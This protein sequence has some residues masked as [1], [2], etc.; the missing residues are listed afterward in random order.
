MQLHGSICALVTPFDADGGI[1]IANLQRLIDWHVDSGT[2]ALVLAGST[3]EAALLTDDEY[4]LLLETAVARSAGRIPVI[5]GVGSPATA[6]S[7][8]LARRAAAIGANALLAVTPYYVRPTQA[9]LLAHYRLLAD[10]GG[11]PVLLYNVPGRTGCDLLPA[12]VAE[13]SAHPA[14]IGIKEA[15]TDPA[16]RREL[17]TLA[18]ADFAVFCGD[19][20][21][22]LQA[23][24]DGAVGTISVAA[25]VVPKTFARLC[26]L[27]VASPGPNAETLDQGLQPLYRALSV[28]SN[29]IPAKWLLHRLGRIDNVL[30]LPLQALN[31]RY[32]AGL[33]QCL[34]EV[35]LLES[36]LD[37]IV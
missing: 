19:D 5:A 1:D 2:N 15:V 12:T 17:L 8:R 13:L 7:L 18:S 22:A 35:Q 34:A 4:A 37:A 24:R 29:P 27:A 20:G 36:R 33:A 14:I 3:G 28:E 11:L 30:R 21:S 9:G 26:A 10:D 32:H 31:N 23:M 16:R 25:N 6:K